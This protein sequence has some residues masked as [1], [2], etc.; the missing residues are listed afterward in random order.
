MC[1]QTD[2]HCLWNYIDREA[3]SFLKATT[4]VSFWQN[5]DGKN[6]GDRDLTY[7]IAGLQSNI[8]VFIALV[9]HITTTQCNC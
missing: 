3:T 4:L 5:S 7:M 8:S 1:E 2:E 6:E 9:S